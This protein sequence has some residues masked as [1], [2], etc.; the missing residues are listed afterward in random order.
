MDLSTGFYA[1]KDPFLDRSMIDISNL[2]LTIEGR[3]LQ[4]RLI[5]SSIER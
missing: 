1:F 3:E 4:K 5:V 2:Y